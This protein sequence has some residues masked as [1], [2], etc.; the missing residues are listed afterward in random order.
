MLEV[1]GRCGGFRAPL[2]PLRRRMVRAWFE[3]IML[4]APLSAVAVL[5][6]IGRAYDEDQ[7]F[8]TNFRPLLGSQ[9]HS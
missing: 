7:V 1:G 4:F 3:V 8:G 2:T 6:V 9:S 5:G